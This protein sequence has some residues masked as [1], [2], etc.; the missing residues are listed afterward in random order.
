MK[1]LYCFIVLLFSFPSFS[2]PCANEKAAL[3][4]M[5]NKFDILADKANALVDEKHQQGALYKEA[6]STLQAEA[7]AL[8][9]RWKQ[10]DNK[11]N[12]L[13]VLRK[14][15]R[16]IAYNSRTLETHLS[17][18]ESRDKEAEDTLNEA[19]HIKD[20]IIPKLEKA[21]YSCRKYNNQQEQ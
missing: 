9:T 1:L 10:I 2:E 5:R 20:K 3:D 4:D 11:H 7:D 13:D 19:E 18:W 8:S 16:S 14:K 15:H 12:L 21:L 6:I 17:L